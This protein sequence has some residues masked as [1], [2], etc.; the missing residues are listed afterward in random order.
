MFVFPQTEADDDDDE[1]VLHP[2]VLSCSVPPS[3]PPLLTV[4][5]L[6]QSSLNLTVYLPGCV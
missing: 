2:S 6:T 5:K 3:P 4:L 1:A